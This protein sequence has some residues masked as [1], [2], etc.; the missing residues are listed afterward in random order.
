MPTLPKISYVLLSHNREK[1]I[2][3][4]LESAFAQDYEGE[5]EYIISDDCSTD[6]TFEI[7]QECVASYKGGRRVVVTQPACNCRTAAN[8]NHALS[9]VQSD[10][11]VRADDDDLSA[12]DRCTVIAK[13]ILQ[14][15]DCMYIATCSPFMFTD[16]EEEQALA[17]SRVPCGNNA[18]IQ[19][20]DA[21]ETGIPPIHFS[22]GKYSY[23]AW[24]MKPYRLFGKLPDDGYYADDYI[25]YW[26]ASVMGKGL[27]LDN[28]AAVLVRSGS[29]N[30]CR[31]KD[32]NT[33]L[34]Q[35]IIRQ[36][37]FS[38]EYQKATI[39][40]LSETHAM[41]ARYV[42]GEAETGRR[43]NLLAFL[44]SLERSLGKKSR[45]SVFWSLAP[46]ER[47]KINRE[48]GMGIAM[49]ILRACPLRIYAAVLAMYRIIAK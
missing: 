30:Q 24:S 9:F 4:A 41:L 17:R 26:R 36:E 49:A 45:L 27:A 18:S 11:V 48:Q 12:V 1:Y 2:R 16:K 31:G 42:Q 28:A 3:A 22:C 35:A 25:F 7:I 40:P 6:R 37:L 10:W 20:I 23:K 14:V 8:F 39:S 15:P 47:Y 33:N 5:L 21:G 19:V 34:I 46:W 44:S 38:Q 13:A 43:N 29:L 32:D